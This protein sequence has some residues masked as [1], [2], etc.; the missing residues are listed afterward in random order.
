MTFSYMFLEEVQN[1]TAEDP[2]VR[3]RSNIFIGRYP[4][5]VGA[6]KELK[7]H[8]TFRQ[9]HTRAPFKFFRQISNTLEKE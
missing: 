1:L 4:Q 5:D 7:N 8:L 3:E 9:E 2:L 6:V